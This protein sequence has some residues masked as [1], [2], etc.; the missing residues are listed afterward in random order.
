MNRVVIL[1][2]LALGAFSAFA[3]ETQRYLVSTRTP[4]R[5]GRLR[6]MSDSA[7]MTRRRVREFHNLNA[8]AADLTA[9]EVA[10]LKASSNVL[11]VEPVIERELLGFDATE[12]DASAAIRYDAAQ[13]TPWGIP[14]IGAPEVWSVSKGSANVHVAVVDTGIDYE[15][16]DLKHAYMGGYNTF[17][18]AKTPLDDHRHGTHVAGT[19]AAGD[20]GFGVVG[21]APGVKLWAVK[22]LDDDG[23]GTSETLTAG[24]NWVIGKAKEVGG[25]WVMN[26][27]LGSRF[28]SDI[29][30]AAIQKAL[31]QNIVIVAACGNTSLP[32]LN[33]PA[34]YKGVI[35]V[36]AANPDN[37]LAAFSTFG[38]GMSVIAPG[39]GVTSTFRGGM[40]TSADVI[41]GKTLI[42]AA[43]LSGSPFGTITARL[44]DC[45]LGRPEDFPANIKN[46]IALIKRGEF[47]FREKARNA[48][49][50]GAAA[51][52]I[53]ND[54]GLPNDVENWTMVYK[55][56]TIN[57]CTMPP[58]WEN[59]VFPLTV[60]A[61][62]ENAP[63][64]LALAG[65][66][67]TVGFRPEDYGSLSGTS[68]AAPHVTGSV[69]MLMS[70][71][72]DLNVSQIQ[73]AIEKTATD[74]GDSG[75]DMHTAWGIIDLP[76]AARYVAPAAFG[77]PTTAPQP[78]SKR[79]GARH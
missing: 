41:I 24:I 74:L 55:D 12:T 34:G 17:D 35:A 9:D 52:V 48:K 37:T 6:V 45:G 66:T 76:A 1:A 28:G 42:D 78:P 64:L 39:V 19:I 22:V 54:E 21:V 65:K 8:F 73:L 47:P 31:A 38:V 67:V 70:L 7:E 63:A 68:M 27:S 20:N 29:E 36:G 26:M 4:L 51:V 10:E 59:Y 58:E 2:F 5:E 11:I 75:W 32:Q 56:C 79:R 18:P 43:G 23:K 57:G 40:N 62:I 16:P 15:H 72:P 49:D 50:A 25:R 30:S 69:A 53:Y 13:Y 33:Y 44:V 60:G 3:E 61:T 46:R 77:L 14:Q 71:A